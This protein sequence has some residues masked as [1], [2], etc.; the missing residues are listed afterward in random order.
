MEVVVFMTETTQELISG[1]GAFPTFT[2]FEFQDDVSLRFAK[3]ILDQCAS[4]IAPVVSTQNL[5]EN[6]VTSLDFEYSV[7]GGATETYTWTGTLGQMEYMDIELPAIPY[8]MQATNNVEI[9]I[10][11]DDNNSNND[12]SVSFD[13]AIE[14]TGTFYLTLNTDNWG[15]ECTWRLEDSNGT[16]VDE[17][18]PYGNNITIEETFQ[19]DEGCYSFYLIDSYGDGGG[20]VSLLD[21]DGT[22]IFATSGN[23]GTGIQ[24]NFG[25]QGNFGIEDNTL[26][27]IVMYPNPA[28][29][30]VTI[31]NLENASVAIFDI[32]GKSVITTTGISGDTSLNVSQLSAGT[33][34]V[35][36]ESQGDTQVKKLVINN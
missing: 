32:V 6:V 26:A 19:L 23:C 1:N 31:T 28:N 4:E 5:G 30:R 11:S 16:I 22:T 18:G 21:S 35:R 20:A 29:D 14:G 17:G 13:E 12:V 10:V 34:F 24:T 36:I 9:S 25:S 2:N 33:Y 8:T 7:N 3:D 15:S 27:N